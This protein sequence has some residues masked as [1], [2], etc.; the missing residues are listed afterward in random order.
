MQL[1]VRCNEQL[2]EI[3]LY[4]LEVDGYY[5][6]FIQLLMIFIGR[7]LLYTNYLT[8]EWII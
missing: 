6:D 8:L 5:T 2:N 4:S 7:Y 3:G 1:F